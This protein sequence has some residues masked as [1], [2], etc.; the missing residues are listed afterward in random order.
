MNIYVNKGEEE[1]EQETERRTW[2]ENKGGWRS[3]RCTHW[4][5]MH[6]L[7]AENPAGKFLIEFV[8]DEYKKYRHRI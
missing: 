5:N 6:P 4:H 8:Q 3:N 2:E 1:T 7:K